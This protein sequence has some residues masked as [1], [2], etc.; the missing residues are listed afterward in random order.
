MFYPYDPDDDLIIAVTGNQ[1]FLYELAK[2]G[3]PKPLPN[4]QIF[5]LNNQIQ[6]KIVYYEKFLYIANELNGI[7]VYDFLNETRP[8]YSLTISTYSL[9]LNNDGEFGYILDLAFQDQILFVLE[10]E[11]GISI[12]Q[13][14]DPINITKIN[15]LQIIG[16]YFENVSLQLLL[17]KYMLPFH[18]LPFGILAYLLVY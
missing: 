18:M 15:F 13:Y 17:L 2:T 1:M 5:N 10:K 14:I 9:G 8:I 3:A 12:Y 16:D 7:D 11:S 4:Y 6:N